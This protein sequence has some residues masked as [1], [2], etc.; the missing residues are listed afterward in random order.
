MFSFIPN[1]IN[2][3]LDVYK[4][5]VLVHFILMLVK[6]PANKWTTLLSSIV[7]PALAP[8]RVLV[9]QYLPKNWQIIDWSPVALLIGISIA[10][11]ALNLVL[12]ILF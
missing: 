1:A 9:N 5:L 11:W 12:G 3:L 8:V 2:T 6:V 10:Q 7:E 4:L